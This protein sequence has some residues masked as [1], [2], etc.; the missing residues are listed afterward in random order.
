MYLAWKSFFFSLMRF[1][2]PLLRCSLDVGFPGAGGTWVN[3]YPV[4]VVG[5]SEPLPHYSLFCV[6]LQTPSFGQIRNFR[7]PNLVTTFYF[8]ELTHFLDRVPRATREIGDVCTQAIFQIELKNTLLFICS[9]N[10]LVR[11]LI[12]N[13]KNCLTPKIRKCATPFQ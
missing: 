7:D 2:L 9:T 6:Q 1:D 10:I 3:F 12:V 5:L 13:M 11:L 4:C 8:Y